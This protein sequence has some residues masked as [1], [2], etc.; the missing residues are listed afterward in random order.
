MV[1]NPGNA[2][3]SR[4]PVDEEWTKVQQESDETRYQLWADTVAELHANSMS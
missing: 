1:Q 3:Q 4:Y 2:P